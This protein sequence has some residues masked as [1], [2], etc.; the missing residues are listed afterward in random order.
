MFIPKNDS[1]QTLD[2]ALPSSCLFQTYW[3]QKL[4]TRTLANVLC[5]CAKEQ[6]R[7]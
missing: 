3:S 5:T 2:F 1:W 7:K 6:G 4:G